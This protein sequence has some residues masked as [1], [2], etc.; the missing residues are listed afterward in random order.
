MVEGSRR[1]RTDRRRKSEPRPGGRVEKG[2]GELVSDLWD[3]LGFTRGLDSVP[4]L[5]VR[6]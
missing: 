5:L 2:R 6:P 1:S 4:S 3:R